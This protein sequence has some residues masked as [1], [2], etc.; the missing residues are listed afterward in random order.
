MPEISEQCDKDTVVCAHRIGKKGCSTS[1]SGKG[2]CPDRIAVDLKANL[3]L[4]TTKEL[5][6]EVAARCAV[7]GTLDYKTVGEELDA[8]EVTLEDARKKIRADAFREAASTV[9]DHWNDTGT[10]V[11][12]KKQAERSGKVL[13]QLAELEEV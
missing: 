1:W 6:E 5:L 7:N 13:R 4:A 10:M 9:D 3:G 11:N 12:Q 8:C 2:E